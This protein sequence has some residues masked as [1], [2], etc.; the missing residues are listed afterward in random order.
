MNAIVTVHTNG[1]ESFITIKRRS[2]Y[3]QTATFPT[4]ERDRRLRNTIINLSNLGYN[5][6]VKD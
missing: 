6:T 1:N 4:S 2:A 5:V 3:A